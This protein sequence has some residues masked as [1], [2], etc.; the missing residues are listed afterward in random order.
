MSF[1][2]TLSLSK[3]RINWLKVLGIGKISSAKALGIIF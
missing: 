3:I 1:F 2:W